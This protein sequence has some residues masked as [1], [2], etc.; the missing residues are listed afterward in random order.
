MLAMQAAGVVTDWLGRRQQ[1]DF[2]QK[3]A[4]LEQRMINEN[5]Q[6]SRIQS[7]EASLQAMK[8]LRQNLGTQ[9]AM[10]AARGIRA[11]AGTA[12]LITNESVGNFNADERM[13]KINQLNTESRLRVGLETSKLHQKAFEA[14]Q[15]NEFFTSV[16]N[17]IPTNPAAYKSFGEGFGLTKVGS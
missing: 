4:E 10:F 1:M 2:A 3:G 5:I 11:G 9:A 16:F 8:Q 12:A 15:R 7:S 17:K 14:N 6:I 13:R